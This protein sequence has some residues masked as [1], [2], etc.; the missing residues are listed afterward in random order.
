MALNF[1][2]TFEQ[3]TDDEKTYTYYLSKACWAGAPIVLFQKSYESPALFIIFQKF[4]S[5]FQ[6]FKELK[7]Q[8]LQKSNSTITDVEYKQFITYAAKFYANFGNYSS[9]GKKMF[10]PEL[11]LEKFEDIHILAYSLARVL[12]YCMILEKAGINEKI[13]TQVIDNLL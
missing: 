6:P 10:I 8:I 2:E 7:K 5:S 4:F 13:I 9:F 3:L 11:P 1:K 12:I